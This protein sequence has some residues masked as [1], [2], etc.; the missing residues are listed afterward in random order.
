MITFDYFISCDN[1][2]FKYIR[3][4]YKISTF[5]KIT[6]RR[7]HSDNLKIRFTLNYWEVE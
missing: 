3:E 6:K 7:Q 4:K 2:L 5:P 1:K